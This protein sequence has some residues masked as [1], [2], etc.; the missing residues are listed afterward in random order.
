MIGFFGGGV[1]LAA[2]LSTDEAGGHRFCTLVG[3]GV[4]ALKG[5]RERESVQSELMFKSVLNGC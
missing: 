4:T 3:L 1:G 5:R 2:L